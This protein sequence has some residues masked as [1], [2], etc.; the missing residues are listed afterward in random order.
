MPEL[1]Q[2]VRLAGVDLDGKRLV[3]QAIRKI[4]GVGFMFSSA[5]VKVGGFENRKLGELSEQEISK[6]EEILVSP[7]KYGIPSWLFN[8]RKNS[9][10]GKDEHLVSAKL[11]LAKKLDIGEL[12][13]LKCYRGVRHILG[14]PVRGQRT[15]SSFRKSTTVGV[16]RTKEEKTKIRGKE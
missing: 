11:E 10:S 14:L 12:K 5:V 4:P 8:R 1:K 2:I 13:K 3:K 9:T 7:G 15:R 6:L 16:K